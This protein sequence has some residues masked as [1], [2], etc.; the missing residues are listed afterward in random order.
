M[1]K[2]GLPWSYGPVEFT[3]DGARDNVV[4]LHVPHRGVIRSI[5]LIQLGG[6]DDGSFEIFDSEAAARAV[7]DVVASQSGSSLSLT[8]SSSIQVVGTDPAVHSLTQGQVEIAA[9][10]YTANGLDLAYRNRDG[11][12]TNPVRRLW[13]V[14]NSEGAGQKTFALSMMFETPF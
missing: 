1:M 9:G 7:E 4:E 12:Y 2:N 5:N 14:I 10:R 8:S 11:N 6:A 3:I 13:L